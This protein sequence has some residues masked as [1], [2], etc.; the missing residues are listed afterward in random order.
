[1][2]SDLIRYAGLVPP[3]GRKYMVCGIITLR[4]RVCDEL[5]EPDVSGSGAAKSLFISD[6]L[7][8]C[9]ILVANA[10]ETTAVDSAMLAAPIMLMIIL[11]RLIFGAVFSMVRSRP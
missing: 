9:T 5:T 2:F 7:I 6:I 4:L 1:M 11:P 8:F 3:D 10:Y